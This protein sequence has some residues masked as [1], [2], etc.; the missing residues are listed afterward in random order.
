MT[1][2]LENSFKSKLLIVSKMEP[3]PTYYMHKSPEA[4]RR[5]AQAMGDRI[6]NPTLWNAT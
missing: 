2:I 3:L 5:H 4:T 6:S 1:C